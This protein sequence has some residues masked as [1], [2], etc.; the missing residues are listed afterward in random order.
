MSPKGDLRYIS[1]VNNALASSWAEVAN[2]YPS[3]YL[4]DVV[5]ATCLLSVWHYSEAQIGPGYVKLGLANRVA[6]AC[7]WHEIES[8]L[9]QPPPPPHTHL[10][11]ERHY[12]VPHPVDSIELGERIWAF[13]DLIAINQ[14][15]DYGLDWA[16]SWKAEEIKTPFPFAHDDVRDRECGFGANE[17]RSVCRLIPVRICRGS[18]SAADDYRVWDLYDQSKPSRPAT[19]DDP[20]VSRIKAVWL[21]Q[22]AHELY[23]LLPENPLAMLASHGMQQ[24][25]PAR[26]RNPRAVWRLEQ[27]VLKFEES[28]KG[29]VREF[30]KPSQAG[31]TSMHPSE[32][33]LVSLVFGRAPVLWKLFGAAKLTYISS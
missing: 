3:L 24:R 16:S 25:P 13:W 18:I 1:L 8:N 12:F 27:A 30:D 32:A 33:F 5:R 9:W 4:L 2:S 28:L 23:W 29:V 15:G 19:L 22:D 10:R 11:R 31:I 26:V 14:A 6:R 17:M 21:L 7:G 20:T